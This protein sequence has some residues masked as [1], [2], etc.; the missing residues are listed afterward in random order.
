MLWSE[1]VVS[2]IGGVG[3]AGIVTVLRVAS[4]RRKVP[5]ALSRRVTRRH[6]LS[7]VLDLSQRGDVHRLDAFV[8]HL[9]PAAND[10][11]L[12]EIQVAWQRV[13]DRLGVRL[14]TRESQEC[15]TAAAELLSRGIDIR[16][17]TALNT[18]EL[19]YHVFS[20]AVH[21]TVLNH[22]EG[23]R[24]RPN[25]LDGMSPAKVFQSHFEQVWDESLPLESV[26][27]DQVMRGLRRRGDRTEIAQQLRDLRSKY[28][29]DPVA[30]EAVVRHIAFRNTAPVVFV[31]GLPGAGKSV[32]RRRLADKL[33]ALR[34]QVDELSDYVYAF[35]D[36]VHNL[37][38]LNEDRGRGFTADVGGAFRVSNEENLRPALDALAQRVWKNRAT[39]AITLVEFARSDVIKAL[40]VF[41]EAVLSSCHL[42]HVRASTEVR[43]ARLGAR[44]QPPRIQITEPDITITVSDDHRL[45]SVVANSLYVVDDYGKLRVHDSVAGRVHAIDNELDD[46]NGAEVDAELDG[47]IENIVR[48]YRT[49]VA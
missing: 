3:V 32:V 23:S 20:G 14:V 17:A 34:F 31:T 33:T 1:L 18:D 10:P 43:S 25:R 4:S 19:S 49:L 7:A 13:N 38:M 21:H 12:R 48:P 28:A 47:F 22:R 45:P 35:H 39:S 24:D 16:V 37:L 9:Q 29:L 5:N 46:P 26:L 2:A 11:V 40:N 36:F 27:A 44:A 30:E 15:L 41:G 42:I 6:Y 8:P